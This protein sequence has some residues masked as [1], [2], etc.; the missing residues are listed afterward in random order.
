MSGFIVFNDGRAWSSSNDGFDTV[1]YALAEYTRAVK[2]EYDLHSWLLDQ[3]SIVLGPG[4]GGVDLREL[5]PHNQELILEAMENVCG[6]NEL[7]EELVNWAKGVRLLVA[8]ARSYRDGEP[9]ESLNPLMKAIVPPTGRHSGP[10][11]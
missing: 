7:P 4:L 2:K 3:R 9:P 11:W 10:G 6:V 8:M 5:T 1:L